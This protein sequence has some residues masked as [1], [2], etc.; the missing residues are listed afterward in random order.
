MFVISFFRNNIYKGILIGRKSKSPLRN[1]LAWSMASL[2]YGRSYL[3]RPIPPEKKELS[4]LFDKGYQMLD[5]LSPDVLQRC[6]NRL[7]EFLTEAEGYRINDPLNHFKSKGLQK[8]EFTK[9]GSTELVHDKVFRELL[10]TPKF[11][12]VAR[13]YLNLRSNEKMRGRVNGWFLGPVEDSKREDSRSALMFHRDKHGPRFLKI[14]IYLTD[15]FEGDGGHEFVAGTHRVF[16]KRLVIN[17]Q[18][19]HF[20]T[21]KSIYKEAEQVKFYGP[22]G[23]CFAEDTI[24]FHRGTPVENQNSGRLILQCYYEPAG[25]INLLGNLKDFVEFS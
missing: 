19:F 23:T 7:S 4:H 15:C 12:D 17:S 5:T 24:G 25:P 3:N 10:E 11:L 9:N 14:F 20:D 6:I 2:G 21:I 22:R 8:I 1:T 18:E 16:K 13:K